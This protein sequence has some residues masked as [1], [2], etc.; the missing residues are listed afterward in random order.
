MPSVALCYLEVTH[1][2]H[3]CCIPTH[4][5]DRTV[6]LAGVVVSSTCDSASWQQLAGQA[7]QMYIYT[8]SAPSLKV[9]GGEGGGWLALGAEGSALAGWPGLSSVLQQVHLQWTC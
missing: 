9:G 4:V 8:A 7:S 3:C 1:G 5:A 2:M 6:V